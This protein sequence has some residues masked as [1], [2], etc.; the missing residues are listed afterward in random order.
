MCGWRLRRCGPT[1][2]LLAFGSFILEP[3]ITTSWVIRLMRWASFGAKCPP[4]L[5]A[6]VNWR[7]RRVPLALHGDGVAVTN[8][9]GVSSKTVEVLSWTSLL[10]SGKT[11]LSTFFNHLGLFLA[12]IVP[13]SAGIVAW[14]LAR[15]NNGRNA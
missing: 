8:I 9:R 12:P 14:G 15:R 7:N 13:E 3:S 2:C 11:R 1:S 5:S 6:R 4:G 10:G